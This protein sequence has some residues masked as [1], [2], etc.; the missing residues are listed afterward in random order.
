MQGYQRTSPDRTLYGHRPRV[1]KEHWEGKGREE[2]DV[3]DPSQALGN[4]QHAYT[5]SNIQTIHTDIYTHV[6][7]HRYATH[8]IDNVR[9]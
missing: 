1:L 8:S 3:R 6:H 2:V 7:L 9:C 5:P 4:Q